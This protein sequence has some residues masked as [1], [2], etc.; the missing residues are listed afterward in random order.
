M[1]GG[2]LNTFLLAK[3][4]PIGKSLAEA[5]LVDEAKKIMAMTEVPL[6]E[7]VVVAGEMSARARGVGDA[8]CAA[9]R[10]TT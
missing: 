5:G 10:R 1:G 7:D 2:I 9:S 6:P 4:F 8:I 3:G